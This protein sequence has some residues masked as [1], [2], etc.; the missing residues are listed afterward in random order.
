MNRS[1]G[2]SSDELINYSRTRKGN[3]ND[4]PCSRLAHVVCKKSGEWLRSTPMYGSSS[5]WASPLWRLCSWR[6]LNISER[7]SCI[8]RQS[9]VAPSSSSTIPSNS[10]VSLFSRRVSDI[11]QHIHSRNKR[12]KSIPSRRRSRWARR[13]AATR[14]SRTSWGG[15]GATTVRPPSTGSPARDPG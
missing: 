2:C 12:H 4:E 14:T 1:D 10:S 13:S 15:P 11:C 3:A 8:H 9:I 5:P 6:R 7:S